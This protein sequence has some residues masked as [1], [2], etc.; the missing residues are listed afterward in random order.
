MELAARAEQD[1]RT[2]KSLGRAQRRRRAR[3]HSQT[4]EQHRQMLEARAARHLRDHAASLNMPGS[5][6]FDEGPNGDK[7][8]PSVPHPPGMF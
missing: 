4:V 5:P 2:A 3:E 7:A 6:S 1:L 8:G